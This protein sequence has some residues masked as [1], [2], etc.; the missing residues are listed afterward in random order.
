MSDRHNP[1]RYRV[2]DTAPVQRLHPGELRVH[3]PWPVPPVSEVALE[4]GIA[5]DTDVL[6]VSQRGLALAAS[7]GFSKA[8]AAALGTALSE[9]GTNIVRYAQKGTIR[10]W[11]HERDGQTGILVEARDKGPGIPDV[12]QALTDGFTTGN[13][14]GDGLGG[15]KR[16]VDRFDIDSKTGEGTTV[17]LLKWA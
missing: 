10:M 17:H 14:L 9:V 15:A 12:E 13:S 11:L 7:S 2:Q 3:E 8:A 6:L 1:F 4:L 16:L 5:D